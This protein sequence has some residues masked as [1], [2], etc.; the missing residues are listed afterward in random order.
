MEYELDFETLHLKGFQC[1]VFHSET[2]PAANAP[3]GCKR[4]NDFQMRFCKKG[5]F[6]LSCCP[7]IE[8]R[9]QVHYRVIPKAFSEDSHEEMWSMWSLPLRGQLHYR[10][11]SDGGIYCKQEI[12]RSL[13]ALGCKANGWIVS[14][15]LVTGGVEDIWRGRNII[16][17]G[18]GR[19]SAVHVCEMSNCSGNIWRHGTQN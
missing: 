11:P 19:W 12:S 1:F 5:H 13:E 6:E 18:I 16:W 17:D 4:K 2:F 9:V 10:R 15:H 7:K 14:M 3:W 8:G